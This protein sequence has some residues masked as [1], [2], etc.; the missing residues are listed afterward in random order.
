MSIPHS[1]PFAVPS[2][3]P[4]E[5]ESRPLPHE[6]QRAFAAVA[7]LA[8]LT[9][10]D[11]NHLCPLMHLVEIPAGEN[12]FGEGDPS[13]AAY[14]L[15]SGDV[16]IFKSD[17][18]D[19]KLPLVT[20]SSAGVIGEM[21]LLSHTPRSATAHA[22]TDA[23]ALMLPVASFEAAMESGNLAVYRMALALA[24]VLTQRLA[25]MDNKLFT[26]FAHDGDSPRF[27]DLDDLRHRLLTSWVV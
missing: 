26:L 5:A 15:L 1:A 7:F 2:L 23:R 27:R 17:D 25:A 12:F 9:P 20:L 10:E 14:F 8:V 16:E 6:C 19:S 22:L 18:L 13:D 21:G 24:R 3:A 4:E 11:V